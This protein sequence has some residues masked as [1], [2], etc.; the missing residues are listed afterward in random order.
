MR[1]KALSCLYLLGSKQ[2]KDVAANEIH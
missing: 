2:V 1:F